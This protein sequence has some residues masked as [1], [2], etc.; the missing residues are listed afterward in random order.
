MCP[1]CD[2]TFRSPKKSGR[3]FTYCSATCRKRA[4][5]YT[6]R[7]KC[8][9]RCERCGANFARHGNARFCSDDCRLIA[10][11]VKRD[12]SRLA[13]VCAQCGDDFRASTPSQRF[14]SNRCYQRSYLGIPE[15]RDCPGCGVPVPTRRGRPGR[16]G[17]C[18]RPEPR[19]ASWPEPPS[20]CAYCTGP[21]ADGRDFCS[22]RCKGL[23]TRLKSVRECSQCGMPWWANS[24]PLAQIATECWTCRSASYVPGGRDRSCITSHRRGVVL[25]REDYHCQDCGRRLP[26]DELD[27]HHVVPEAL[28][29]THEL[30]NLRLLCHD[31]HRGSGWAR[32]HAA[33]IEAGLVIPPVDTQLALAA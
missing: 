14:C 12:P 15:L 5:K 16:C 18:R 29:G 33:L 21:C 7:P 4:K 19:K 28:G 27:C 26:E 13:K 6:P 1:A 8:K 3:P 11:G 31:C 25:R 2:T 10:A 9:G 23:N 17:A 30:S 32:N 24:R 20:I 22:Q